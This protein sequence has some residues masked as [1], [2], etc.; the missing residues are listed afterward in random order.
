MSPK[1]SKS[2]AQVEDSGTIVAWKLSA[3]IERTSRGPSEMENG[4]L[5]HS[6]V[7]LVSGSA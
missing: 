7:P 5:T 6:G 2:I 1:P 3:E 4:V